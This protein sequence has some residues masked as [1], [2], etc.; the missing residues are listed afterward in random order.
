MGQSAP[1]EFRILKRSAD[2]KL[3]LPSSVDSPELQPIP[4]MYSSVAAI[5]I[6]HQATFWTG[7]FDNLVGPQVERRG[8]G[9]AQAP[10]R[11]RSERPGLLVVVRDK[12]W[13]GAGRLRAGRFDFT[14]KKTLQSF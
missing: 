11:L 12:V 13:L 7:L 2:F 6:R 1:F 14:W 9:D 4:T 8:K 3:K 5:R 10:A